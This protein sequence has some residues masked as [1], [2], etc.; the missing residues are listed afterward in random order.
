MVSRVPP[1]K[2]LGE[3]QHLAFP[4][5]AFR[6]PLFLPCVP[7]VQLGGRA[8]PCYSSPMV[9][10]ADDKPYP[11]V[12]SFA[13]PGWRGEVNA[14]FAG[15]DLEREVSRLTDPSAAV[16]SIYWGRNYLYAAAMESADG[17]QEVAVKQF[18]NQ[19]LL[20]R[21]QRRLRG[22]KAERSW[23][24]A[25]GLQS[26]GIPTPEPVLVV[27]STRSDGPSFFVT[28]RLTG[29]FEVR[30]FFRRVNRSG[31]A[32]DFPAIEAGSFLE[33]LGRF[34]REIHDGGV[35][36][37]DL[38]MGNVLAEELEDGSTGLLVVDCNRARIGRRL[39][40]WRRCRDSCRF[41]INT[42]EHREAFLRG[43]WG[44][45][46]RSYEFRRW[47]WIAGMA[48]YRLK[49]AVKNRLKSIRIRGR[50][51][52]GGTHHPHIPD[53]AANAS[54]RDKT[55][56]DHLSD[57]PHQHA[58]RWEKLA[59]RAADSGD[60][61]RGMAIVAASAPAVWRRY[62]ALDAQLYRRSV[63]FDGIG[64]AVRPWPED[65]ENHL[66]AIDKLGAKTV[67]IRLHPWEKDHEAEQRLAAALHQR[68]REVAF[69]VP[70]TRDLVRDRG[71]WR[72]AIE[73]ISE[74]F[75]PYGRSFQVGQAP[76][77]SKWGL[78]T[79]GEYVELYLE[80]AE[81]LRRRNDVEV[82]GPAVIDFEFQ[83][84][85]ALVNR[86]KSGLAFD[87]LSALLYVDR[88]GA[89]ENTQLGLDTVGKVVL[90][91]AISEVGRNTNGRCWITEVNW[92]LLEGPHSPAGRAASVDESA[93]ADYLARYYLMTI[94]TGLVERVYWWRLVARGYGLI[95]PDRES[96][97]RRR[98]AFE[99]MRTMIRE[100]EGS[101]FEGPIDAPEG[102]YL[103][104]FKRTDDEVIVGWTTTQPRAAELPRPAVRAIGRDGGEHPVPTGTAVT[105]T[106][107]PAY[108]VLSP[109]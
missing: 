51:S 93:Q 57:Q 100:L 91:R 58:G 24:A 82:L 36:Y 6:N 70:Q 66:A 106:S 40:V 20:K 46:P 27:E 54:L 109:P 99:A 55:V 105:L 14:A 85:L 104:R 43:Y 7:A 32:G 96:E 74:L 37:R 41:P 73:E 61:L 47:F 50:H 103:Y 25:W 80:A 38:S 86:R 97:F 45:V 78:W 4:L 22:S 53:A 108:Y 69:A 63:R 48:G 3:D 26:A 79:R 95:S 23:A 28:R 15:D 1:E 12:R 75:T 101:S 44:E 9:A 59:I 72:A 71:R 31:D 2:R 49:H 56:W 35:W 18:Q 67:L 64:V 90:L 84:T 11:G 52:R 81:I 98:P 10:V 94:G 76:N 68:G 17:P 5:S 39:G 102:G 88:R 62:R 87:A 16:E 42:V 34:C 77:R 29:V 19:G 8:F 65:P 13:F 60:H 33:Q 83:H 107:S 30:H 92:P 21:L 89:P